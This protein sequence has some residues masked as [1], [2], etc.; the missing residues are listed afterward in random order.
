MIK[1]LK[2]LLYIA[3]FGFCFLKPAD[4]RAD[5]VF[6]ARLELTETQPGV[7]DVFFILPVVNGKVLKASPVLPEACTYQTE[8]EITGTPNT[9]QIT[10]SIDCQGEYIYGKQ[11]GIEGLQGSQVEIMLIINLLDGRSYNKKLSP[12]MAYF[13]VPE[14][15]TTLELLKNGMINGTRS[16]LSQP[17]LYLILFCLVIFTGFGSRSGFYPGFFISILIGYWLGAFEMMMTPQWMFNL[18]AAGFTLLVALKS[19]KDLTEAF[20]KLLLIPPGLF[21]GNSLSLQEFGLILTPEEQVAFSVFFSLGIAIGILLSLILFTQLKN[22]LKSYSVYE[23]SLKVFS[24]LIGSIGLGLLIFESSLFWKTTSMLPQIPAMLILFFLLLPL[25]RGSMSLMISGLLFILFSALGLTLAM[26]EISLPYSELFLLALILI[27]GVFMLGKGMVPNFMFL[28]LLIM[29]SFAAGNIMGEYAN[30]NISYPLARSVGYLAFGLFLI[31]ILGSSVKTAESSNFLKAVSVIITGLAVLILFN[32]FSNDYF[33]GI[34]TAFLSG[35][36]PIPVISILLLILA[37]IF[38]PRNRKVH[39]QMA[40]KSRKPLVSL[41]MVILAV[42]LLPFHLNINN[43]WF[44]AE[45]LDQAGMERIMQ[46]V[47]SNTY[48]AFNV[49]DEEKLFEELSNNVDSELLDNVYLDSRRRLNMG[50]REGAE[51]SVQE[52]ELNSMGKP[53]VLQDPESIEY[54]AQW[55]VTARVR[56]LKHIHYRK[57]QYTGTVALKAIDN[58]WKISKISLTSEE[59]K[60][61]AASSL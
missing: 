57:N 52:V 46:N 48:S 26:N 49:E 43:P 3:L 53:Q 11:I 19:R 31:G 25:L 17:Y 18:T 13:E 22:I 59:R 36:L 39:R 44:E 38:W 7:F 61:I 35:N 12:A 45:D 54:P 20:S 40:L 14:P 8:P 4:F 29:G 33:E 2:R 28:I 32:L 30:N 15:P 24:I 5:I 23:S 42:I 16:L 47:L 41:S 9:K 1:S 27:S 55:T 56:H 34:V 51:V 37:I 6:P 58:K 60:V 50:L 10:W 21:L